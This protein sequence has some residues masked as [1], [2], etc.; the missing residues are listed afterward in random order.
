MPISYGKSRLRR[1]VGRQDS[2]WPAPSV[3]KETVSR[4]RFTVVGGRWTEWKTKLLEPLAKW[5]SNLDAERITE[6][7]FEKFIVIR[8]FD[9]L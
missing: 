2:Q 3:G 7:E 4:K 5:V 1:H 8:I 6:C 9:R